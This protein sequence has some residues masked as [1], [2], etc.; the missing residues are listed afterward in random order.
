MA[1]SAAAEQTIIISFL[2]AFLIA[3]VVAIVVWRL[4]QGPFR[5]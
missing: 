5:D 3:A 2:V 1:I 4:W